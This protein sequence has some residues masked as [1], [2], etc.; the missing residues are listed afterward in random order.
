MSA[1]TLLLISY[2]VPRGGWCSQCYGAVLADGPC[3]ACAR[4][5]NLRPHAQSTQPAAACGL[6]WRRLANGGS[7]ATGPTH[8]GHKAALVLGGRVEQHIVAAQ[9]ACRRN[10]GG[11]VHRSCMADDIQHASRLRGHRPPT[12]QCGELRLG[13]QA[14]RHA[15][16]PGG[17]PHPSMRPLQRPPK[18]TACCCSAHARWLTNAAPRPAAW[19][20]YRP[21][22]H[23]PA[24]LNV[25]CTA[26]KCLSS[27]PCT[28]PLECK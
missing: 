23:V 1:Q 15:A 16:V 4:L 18:S 11:K 2:A 6:S 8:H 9:I 27:S 26:R 17:L 14:G 22:L 7:K 13:R 24:H 5:A 20:G 10:G 25:Q 12:K 3:R 19:N 21:H 28:T